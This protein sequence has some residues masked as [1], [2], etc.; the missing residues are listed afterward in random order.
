V[1]HEKAPACVWPGPGPRWWPV[2]VPSLTRGVCREFKVAPAFPRDI[3]LRAA[4]NQAPLNARPAPAT[5]DLGG[6]R[7]VCLRTPAA[8]LGSW[9]WLRETGCADLTSGASRASAGR[10]GKLT[11][12]AVRT[13]GHD[14]TVT[15]QSLL[16]RRACRT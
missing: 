13:A 15:I 14:T 16:F 7:A 10:G 1:G 8:G 4:E 6:R 11:I 3:V 9:R 5:T 2:R 12:T